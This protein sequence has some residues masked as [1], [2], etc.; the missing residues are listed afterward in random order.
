[1]L[2]V[3]KDQSGPLIKQVSFFLKNRIGALLGVVRRLEENNV[4]ICALSILDSADHAVIRMV[5]DR[6]SLALE[7]LK[8]QGL[9]VFET[10]L[11]GVEVSQPQ[12]GKTGIRKILSALLLAEINVHYVYSL[13][14]HAHE[15]HRPVFALHVDDVPTSVQVL[16]NHGLTIVG[17][18]EISWDYD[19]V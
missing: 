8:E 14:A 13:I 16:R 12:H 17:Q 19:S 15:D 9:T 11:L 5:V 10:E 18:D 1:M 7:T 2:E 3:A 4:H 6:P